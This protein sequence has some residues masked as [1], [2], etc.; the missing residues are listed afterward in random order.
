MTER[1][2]PNASATTQ[3]I[4]TIKTGNDKNKWIVM[5]T[6]SGIKRWIKLGKSIKKYWTHDNGGRPFYFIY[7][8]S[9]IL[10][11]RNTY[12]AEEGEDFVWKFCMEI[13]KFTKIFIGKN[14]K[15]YSYKHY[16]DND[17]KGSSI[18]VEIKP[19]KYIFIGSNILEFETIEPITSY[20]SLMGNSD[21]I[22]PFAFTKNFTYLIINNVYNEREEN[23]LDPYGS[24]YNLSENDYYPK[25]WKTYKQKILQ[26]RII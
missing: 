10:I 12:T 22:Y 3:P 6:T 16:K 25:K 26:K 19:Q 24:F 14:I 4:A 9:K 1:Q 18:L 13:K 7:T 15:K 2:S 21:V 11:F 20:V 23:D 5:E 17:F 8:G